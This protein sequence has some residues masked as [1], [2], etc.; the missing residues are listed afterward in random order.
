MMFYRKN[1]PRATITPKLHMLE[2]HVLPWMNQWHVGFGCMGEQGAESLHAN[3]NNTE[4]SYINM[5]NKVDR[6]KRVLENHHLQ[7]LP[8][9]TSLHPPPLK[10]SKKK[11]S[12]D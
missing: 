10:K 8:S 3:F 1:F 12:C 7:I 9:N 6:L 2:D 11:E 5:K 4:R